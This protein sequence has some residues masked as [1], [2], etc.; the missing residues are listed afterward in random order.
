M[1]KLQDTDISNIRSLTHITSIHNAVKELILNSLDASA[2]KI[3]VKINLQNFSIQVEDDGVGILPNDLKL[4][5]Q[6][7]LTSKSMRLPKYGFRGEALASLGHISNLEIISKAKNFKQTYRKVIENGKLVSFSPSPETQLKG[8]KITIT[9]FF[10]NFPLRQK[11]I[12]LESLDLIVKVIEKIC[13][14]SPNLSINVFDDVKKQKVLS[15]RMTQNSMF[16][17]RELFGY[18]EKLETFDIMEKS[19][20]LNGFISKD[21]HKNNN[22]QFLYVNGYFIKFNAI[23]HYLQNRFSLW[24]KNKVQNQKRDIGEPEGNTV[25]FSENVIV[26][27]LIEK[28]FNEC[29]NE[30]NLKKVEN[31]NLPIKIMESKDDI[32]APIF[33]EIVKIKGHDGLFW[34]QNF[35]NESVYEKKKNEVKDLVLK[36]RLEKPKSFRIHSNQKKNFVSATSSFKFVNDEILNNWTSHSISNEKLFCDTFQNSFFKLS[37]FDLSKK[38]NDTELRLILKKFDKSDLSNLLLVS[39]VD[40][41]FIVCLL[42]EKKKLKNNTIVILD[43]HAIDERIKLE[44]NLKSLFKNDIDD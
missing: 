21:P 43:Q 7:Y 12:K 9:D 16:T 42:K 18:T 40:K 20:H 30:I 24:L 35:K 26:M 28:L 33:T 2:T 6:R 19:Y 22:F 38:M 8:T 44:T 36:G 41:K 32:R 15:S 1:K 10:C 29:F 39:Q 37:T 17:F 13:L 23:H 11:M 34:D 25:E 14:I 3:I 27:D 31:K 5:G 4:I